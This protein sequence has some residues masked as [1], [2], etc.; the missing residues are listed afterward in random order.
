[1]SGPLGT[2]RGLTIS[3]AWPRGFVREPVVVGRSLPVVGAGATSKAA[4]VGLLLLTAYGAVAWLWVHRRWRKE[5]ITPLARP[6]ADVSPATARFVMTRGYDARTLVAVLVA[7]AVKGRLTI[8][9]AGPAVEPARGARP[10]PPGGIAADPGLPTSPVAP[11]YDLVKV[12]GGLGRPRLSPEEGAVLT[13]LLGH[14][15][16]F[17]LKPAN[18]RDVRRA[19]VEVERLVGAL[20]EDRYFTRNARYQV[21]AFLICLATIAGCVLAE[22]NRVSLA[23]GAIVVWCVVALGLLAVIV[24]LT[25]ILVGRGVGD[26]R[27]GRAGTA[28][29]LAIFLLALAIAFLLLATIA[30]TSP[31]VVVVIGLV[32]VVLAVFRLLL[33]LPTREG[34]RVR[35]QL[36]GLKAFLSSAGRE[37]GEVDAPGAGRGERDAYLPYAIALAVEKEWLAAWGERLGNVEKREGPSG[38]VDWFQP[39][40]D[41]AGANA[42]PRGLPESIESLCAVVS[43]ALHGVDAQRAEY[44]AAA[45]YGPRP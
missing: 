29:G 30:R 42:V 44:F 14:E 18:D 7:L 43:C 23:L 41:V 31:L 13:E 34:R 8:R 39:S 27:W 45:P 36:D 9:E 37:T 6:P 21:P 15:R 1:V 2:G 11:T 19:R 12:D 40:G 35:A 24:P 26:R 28:I 16:V 38:R 4:L 17:H 22:T 20:D 32:G 3:V 33:I 5:A 10:E 25:R